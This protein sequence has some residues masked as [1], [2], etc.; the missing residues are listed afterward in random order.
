MVDRKRE[1]RWPFDCKRVII[2][3]P[4][5]ARAQ[6]L[7][8]GK[9]RYNMY[10]HPFQCHQDSDGC[11]RWR[12]HD[13]ACFPDVRSEAAVTTHK[14]RVGARVAGRSLPTGGMDLAFRE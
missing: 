10:S 5:P 12:K 2:Y 11:K 9:L 8:G 14:T 1:V 13:D 7:A 3:L 4:L 6:H